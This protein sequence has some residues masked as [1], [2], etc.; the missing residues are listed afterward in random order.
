[1]VPAL[2]DDIETGGITVLLIERAGKLRINLDRSP[3]IENIRKLSGWYPRN[4][5]NTS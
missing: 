5:R 2:K 1:M 3:E 4:I